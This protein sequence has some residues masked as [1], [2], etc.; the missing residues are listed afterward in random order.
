M[1]FFVGYLLENRPHRERS[2]CF[3][4]QI[5]PKARLDTAEPAY[6]EKLCAVGSGEF[7]SVASKEATYFIPVFEIL[8]V[9]WCFAA[10]VLWAVA[11]DEE[12]T[13]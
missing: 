7:S 4:I 3:P 9:V 12:K 10:I 13:F 2:K 6:S 1:W 11:A 8:Q 5:A